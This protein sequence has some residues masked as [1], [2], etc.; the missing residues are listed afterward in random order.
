MIWRYSNRQGTDRSLRIRGLTLDC[1]GLWNLEKDS[2]TG[3]RRVAMS[4]PMGHEGH[5]YVKGQPLSPE[6]GPNS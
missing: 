4:Q 5:V 3:I 1:C 6:G 2:I